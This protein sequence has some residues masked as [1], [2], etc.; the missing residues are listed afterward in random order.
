[1]PAS[2]ERS[3]PRRSVLAA[4]VTGVVGLI[5]AGLT[6]LVGLVAA[7]KSTGPDRRWRRAA[8]TTDIPA[9]QPLSVVIAER[10][11]DGWYDTRRESV[12]FVDREGD[13][14]RVLSATCQHLGCRVRWDNTKHQFLCPCHGGV[15]DRQGAVVAGPPPRG[16]QRLTVRVND[17]TGDIEVEL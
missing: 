12:V 1:M 3:H 7:P 14:Y 5:T 6:G 17:Q 9:N 8:S 11:A 4:L 15:Y 10:H 16:L 2:S 13:G